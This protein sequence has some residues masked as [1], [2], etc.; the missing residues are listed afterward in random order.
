MVKPR[1]TVKWLCA[2]C[3]NG[4]MSRIESNTKPILIS[5]LEDK[6]NAM[7]SSSQSTLA[8]WAVKT[9]MVLECINPERTWFYTDDER[10]L[11]CATQSISPRTS[12][13]IA[14]CV[15]QSNIYSAAKDLRT[16]KENNGVHAY[17]TTLA[18][19]SLAFQV[20]SIKVPKTIPNN[21][22]L[23]YDVTEGP[24]EQTLVQVWPIIQESVGWPA[25]YGLNGERGLDALTERLSS[26]KG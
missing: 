23:T 13:W 5:I 19:G 25:G 2:K 18:F 3:N 16:S 10:Q 26:E 7:D 6:L 17:A 11:M 8:S 22:T 24:W 14:K 12:V 21:V 4:W 20:V 9:S 1:L 15:E